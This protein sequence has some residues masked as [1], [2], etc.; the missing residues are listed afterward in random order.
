MSVTQAPMTHRVQLE[1]HYGL[2]GSK[3]IHGVVFGTQFHTGTLFGPS[4]LITFHEPFKDS[5][6]Q[7]RMDSG[8]L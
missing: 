8:S 6:T 2:E 4:G 3:T 5:R 7:S 1:G